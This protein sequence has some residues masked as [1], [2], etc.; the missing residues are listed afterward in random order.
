MGQRS[1]R[2]H[3]LK[4]YLFT[5]PRHW[6]K[7]LLCLGALLSASC[8]LSVARPQNNPASSDARPYPLNVAVDEVSLTFHPPASSTKTKTP[9]RSSLSKPTRIFQFIPASS[10]IP[11]DLCSDISFATRQ[12]PTNTSPISSASRP[13]VPS[14]WVSTPSQ[15]SYRIGQPTLTPSPPAFATSTLAI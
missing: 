13:I 5:M 7:G 11:A 4:L 15:R 14:S 3:P 10:S 9:T 6:S 1:L 12:S 2:G 8:I